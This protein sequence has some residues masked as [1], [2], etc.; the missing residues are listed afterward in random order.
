MQEMQV[1]SLGWEG[2]LEKEMTIHSSMVAW[3]IPLTEAPGGLQS[4][5][6]QT[7]GYALATKYTNTHK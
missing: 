5:E 3:R 6:L 2:S 1:Q 7:F 4:M